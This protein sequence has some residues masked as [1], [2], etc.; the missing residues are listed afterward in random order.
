[1]KI[2]EI[3]YGA[4]AVVLGV[5]ASKS[6][7]KEGRIYNKTL[8]VFAIASG[9]L[10][11]VYYGYYARDLIVIFGINYFMIAVVSLILFY[12]H[13]FAG[14][15][16]KLVLVM[17]LLYPANYYFTYGNSMA[18]LVFALGISILY[19][20]LYLLVSSLY[21]LV[22][23]KNRITKQYIK[24]YFT[25]FLKSFISAMVYIISSQPIY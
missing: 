17:G 25:S 24:G 1:M 6:D 15:D 2:V 3:I 23:K 9:L 16:C 7:L 12:S 11:I 22:S 5:L 8:V 13:S 4:L 10:G 21:G 19:G 20:Y 18:T 14:G